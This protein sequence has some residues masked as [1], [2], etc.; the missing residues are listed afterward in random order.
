M[1]FVVPS[2]DVANFVE[3]DDRYFHS[4]SRKK[5]VKHTDMRIFRLRLDKNSRGLDPKKYENKWNYFER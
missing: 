3:K 5:P 2:V 1:F 4:L